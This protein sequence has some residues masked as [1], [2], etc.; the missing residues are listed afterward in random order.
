MIKKEIQNEK[1]QLAGSVIHH[2]AITGGDQL[3][4]WALAFI[5]KPCVNPFKPILNNIYSASKSMFTR[6]L[7]RN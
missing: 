2:I 1:N 3:Y 4:D 5:K 7:L 6:Y